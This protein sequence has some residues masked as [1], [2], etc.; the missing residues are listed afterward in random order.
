MAQA[1]PSPLKQGASQAAGEVSLQPLA[2]G[3][4]AGGRR[5]AQPA[6]SKPSAQTIVA[7]RA[8]PP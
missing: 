3:E 5:L 1:V 8:G 7:P 2:A 4:T 6:P